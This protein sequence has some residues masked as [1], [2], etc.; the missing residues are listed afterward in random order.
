MPISNSCK[1]DWLAEKQAC[2]RELPLVLLCEQSPLVETCRSP[3]EIAGKAANPPNGTLSQQKHFS[4]G[5]TLSLPGF[6]QQLC[7]LKVVTIPRS[8][9]RLLCQQAF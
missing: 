3:A 6:C 2:C 8:L 5:I 9:P 1:I 7:Q 4:V